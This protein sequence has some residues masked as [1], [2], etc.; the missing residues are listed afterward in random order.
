MIA[1]IWMHCRDEKQSFFWSAMYPRRQIRISICMCSHGLLYLS[2]FPDNPAASE[3]AL[4]NSSLLILFDFLQGILHWLL[5]VCVCFCSLT[6]VAFLVP[7][8]SEL[9]EDL[10]FVYF[11]SLEWCGEENEDD[12]GTSLARTNLCSWV[13][14]FS[15]HEVAD[16]TYLYSK[17]AAMGLGFLEFL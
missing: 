7:P 10:P 17:C 1:M 12:S 3:A 16:D 9:Q 13:S 15:R 2:P 6:G 5:F 8:E 14:N 4:L 11:G